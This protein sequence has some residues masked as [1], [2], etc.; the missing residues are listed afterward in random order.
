MKSWHTCSF[1]SKARITIIVIIS[2][3]TIFLDFSHFYCQ[4]PNLS[5]CPWENIE[6]IIPK[7]S[8]PLVV[9]LL[10]GVECCNLNLLLM[11]DMEIARHVPREFPESQKSPSEPKF[12]GTT[13]VLPWN[14]TNN[15]HLFGH[16]ICLLFPWHVEPMEFLLFPLFKRFFPLGTGASDQREVNVMKTAKFHKWCL[17]VMVRGPNPTTISWLFDPI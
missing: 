13:L 3:I 17:K 10:S 15:W 7:L 5:I 2:F 9:F 12:C 16:F 6:I 8:K 11:L 14:Q 4:Y 1:G